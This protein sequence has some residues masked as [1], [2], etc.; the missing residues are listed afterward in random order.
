MT[1]AGLEQAPMLKPVDALSRLSR[2]AI[3]QFHESLDPS[4]R[5]PRKTDPESQP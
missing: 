1:Y 2:V 3:A 5:G 4:P